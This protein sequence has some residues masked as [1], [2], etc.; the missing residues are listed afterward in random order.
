MFKAWS[1]YCEQFMRTPDFLN[2][3]KQSLS[4]SLEARKQLNDFLA[5]TQHELQGASRQDAD[6]IMASIQRMEE[7]L[8]DGME[9][10]TSRLQRL[11]GRLEKLESS[12]GASGS[13][14]NKQGRKKND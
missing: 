9:D 3:M 14:K 10:M 8:A 4:A 1:D 13:K 5:R 6:Q 2:M 7:R 12:N 11:E